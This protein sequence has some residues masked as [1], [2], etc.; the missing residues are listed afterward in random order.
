MI[1]PG[2]LAMVL[3]YQYVFETAILFQIE[4]P[5]AEGPQHIFHTLHRHGRQRLQ[6]I[7]RFNHH[8]MGANAIHLVKHAVC[9]AVQIA[10]DSQCRK[11]IGNHAQVPA[12]SVSPYVFTWT[13]SQDF[14]RGCI[15]MAGTKR[16]E[17][18]AFDHSGLT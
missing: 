14:W 13:I 7:G 15:F 12:R 17:A 4:N 2:G 9:L 8:F 3:E 11:F 5:V 1:C 18:A 6:M 16:T 10:F